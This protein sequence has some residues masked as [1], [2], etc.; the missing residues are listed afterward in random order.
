MK[1][2][3]IMGLSIG[4]VV[5]L[6]ASIGY[7]YYGASALATARY[8]KTD[9]QRKVASFEKQIRRSRARS[10]FGEK[11]EKVLARK[12]QLGLN[13]DQWQTRRLEYEQQMVPRRKVHEI[14]RSV[15]SGGKSSFF[16]P[17]SFEVSVPESELGLFQN[18]P[19]DQAKIGFQLV[20]TM[21]LWVGGE[22]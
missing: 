19:Y 17:R 15:A 3:G 8:F 5:M 21:Y 9:A 16:L 18:P 6:V 2:S 4:C 13:A 10:E 14:L 11:L 1:R 12:D 7:A 22:S 20:G